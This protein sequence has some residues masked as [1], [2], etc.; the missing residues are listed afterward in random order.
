MILKLSCQLQRL[1]LY[2]L[3]C[4][5]SPPVGVYCCGPAPVV[6]ILNGETDL[7]YDTP[8]VYAE[9]NADC[10]DWLVSEQSLSL[11]SS[12]PHLVNLV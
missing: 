4:P 6:A 11:I 7:K 5:V 1:L 2:F 3:I 12:M 8:F 9:V 10:I